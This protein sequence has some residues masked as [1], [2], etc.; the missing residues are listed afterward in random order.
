LL[1]EVSQNPITGTSQVWDK[2]EGERKKREQR[3]KRL[4]KTKE[5]WTPQC[6]WGRSEGKIIES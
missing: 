6:K 3:N 5:A 1:T 4:D 2:R